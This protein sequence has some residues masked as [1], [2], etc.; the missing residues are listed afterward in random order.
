M[1]YIGSSITGSDVGVV[2]PEPGLGIPFV[3][4]GTA[5][6]S[7]TT[8]DQM[9]FGALSATAFFTNRDTGVTFG[10][11][12]LFA[13]NSFTQHLSVDFNQ[14][15]TYDVTIAS[16]FLSA[17]FADT[18]SFGVSFN[19]DVFGSGIIDPPPTITLSQPTTGFEDVPFQLNSSDRAALENWFSIVVVPE[20]STLALAALGGLALLAWR[21]RRC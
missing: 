14:P 13:N 10:R 6:P 9:R 4:E 16:P 19:V 21:W 11:S 5:S 2:N 7:I 1:G 3:L 12:I 18:R 8:T 17:D 15:G 20:P